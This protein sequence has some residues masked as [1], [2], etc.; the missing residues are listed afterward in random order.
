[1]KNYIFYTVIALFL[2]SCVGD[3]KQVE[4]DTVIDEKEVTVEIDTILT[5]IN[6]RIRADIN[7]VGLYLERAEVY[8]DRE[9]IAAAKADIDRAYLIDSTD[10]NTLLILADFWMNSGKLG[11]SL[12][13]LE[14][15]EIFH[16]EN[17]IINSK[18]SE[19]F[20]VGRDN[21]KSMKYADL[22]VK[23]D[24]FNA[25]AYYLKGF[26]YL[27]KGDTNRAISSYQTAIEQDPD[28]YEPYAELGVLF[29][30]RHDPLAIQYYDNALAIRPNERNVLYS[31]GMY[32]QEH[33][34]Y[35]DAIQTYFKATQLFP[36]F[37]EAHFNLG[38]V[39]MYYLKINRVA[40][41]HFT[42]AVEV[43]PKYYQ[44]YYNRGYSF[45][46]MG[47]ITNAA[48]DYQYALSIKPDYTNAALGLERVTAPF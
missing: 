30:A 26:N 20:L 12:S 48:K 41:Q 29:A 40:V 36:D 7:N 14:K 28:Y 24:I 11:F 23:Y 32:L 35:N 46:L 37:R 25:K 38:Y 43:D 13:V 9:D 39:H 45:E 10:L 3:S 34:L 21:E 22:A 16:P 1:M 18:L 19:L 5:E 47:D 33:G 31:K 15:A 2:I 27:E 4:D 8:F 17:S 6:D 44:A 42:D